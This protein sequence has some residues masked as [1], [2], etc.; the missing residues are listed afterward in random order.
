[1]KIGL[2]TFGGPKLGTG[3]IFRSIAFSEW[4]RLKGLD[5]DVEFEF[6]DADPH[7]AEAGTGIIASRTSY[8][9][10]VH[11]DPGLPGKS[12]DILFVDRL[13]VPFDA[14]KG[15]RDRARII[16]SIDDTGPARQLA[17]VALNPLYRSA[18]VGGENGVAVDLQGPE[19]QIIRP[20]FSK[21]PCRWTGEVRD[22]LITQGG[23]DPHKLAPHLA[24]DLGSLLPESDELT[25]H[26]ITGPGFRAE[27][28]LT[29]LKARM[30]GRLQQHKNVLDMPGLLRSMDVAVSAAGV[31]PFELAALGLP[32]VLVTG[33]AKEVETADSIHEQGAAY[34]LGLYD[35]TVTP[36]LLRS[37]VRELMVS[38]EKREAMRTAGLTRLDGKIGGR[39]VEW[40]QA[41]LENPLQPYLDMM[42]MPNKDQERA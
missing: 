42:L 11:L 14:M 23:A 17:D 28:A 22:I 41:A 37:T 32:A 25:L 38:P 34:S 36:D 15:L 39:L 20:E 21:K 19:Y 31:A 35:A 12:W 9:F 33:E 10:T 29:A 18:K 4:L 24:S 3:H 27:E 6:F 2:Y 7:G 1:V 16:I 40:A 13:S 30:G 8:D 26:V 5:G